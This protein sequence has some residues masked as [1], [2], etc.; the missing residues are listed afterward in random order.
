MS[1]SPFYYHILIKSPKLRGK[2]KKFGGGYRR[3]ALMRSLTPDPPR[4]VRTSLKDETVILY[5]DT[6]YFGKGIR[7][8]GVQWLADLM[9]KKQKLEQQPYTH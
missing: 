5:C 6:V 3:I 2:A 7:S 1:L 9:E 8:K 4:T